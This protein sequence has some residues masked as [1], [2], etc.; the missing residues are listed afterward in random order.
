MQNF[1]QP[2]GNGC[3]RV[4]IAGG[5]NLIE[6]VI[7][8]EVLEMLSTPPEIFS[9]IE[10]LERIMEML[11]GI[12]SVNRG[13]TPE[14]LKS[15]TALA[16]VASQA[17][18]FSSGLQRSYVNLQQDIG[19]CLLY[20]LKDFV[21]MERQA[22]IAG[23]FNRP[24]LTSYTGDKLNKIDKVV[25]E[26]TSALSKTQAGKI[27]I[28]QDLLQSGLIRSTREYLNVI[29]TGQIDTMWESE[30]SEIMLVKAE[31][32]DLRAGKTVTALACDDHKL[33]WLEHRAILG[34]PEARANPQL[35]QNTLTHMVEHQQMSM[36]LQIENPQL[37]AWMGETPMPMPMQAPQQMGAMVNPQNPVEKQAE[38]VNAPS[39]PNMPKNADMETKGSYE[40]Q[41]ATQQ[42][43]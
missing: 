9:F 5:L 43:Q 36:Q 22:V 16:Y 7:K 17:I 37:L 41:Q 40:K 35:I 18:T 2:P 24:M 12:S 39:A 8:P 20:I 33:H 6:S 26:A 42:Q 1:W 27:Q 3:T 19:T 25:V 15:G 11:V 34:N 4:Q 30:M 38:N 21:P 32:E 14:N 10:K 13:E 28:A 31:N 29:T 23:Q